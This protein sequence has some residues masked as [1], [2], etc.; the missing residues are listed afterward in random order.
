[1]PVLNNSLQPHAIAGSTYGFSGTRIDRLGAAEY[2]LVAIAADDSGSVIDFRQDME[3]CV[4]RVVCACLRSPRA[5]NL[6]LRVLRFDDNVAEIHGFKPVA[7]CPPDDYYGML[8]AGGWTALHDAAHNAVESVIR[9]GGDLRDHDFEVNGIVFVITDGLDNA[10]SVGPAAVKK[11]VTA[12]LKG[13]R[14][15]SLVTVLVGVDV[16]NPDVA[17][18]LAEFAKKAG[19]TGYV[20]LEKADERTLAGL[21]DFVSRSIALQSR[22]LGTGSAGLVF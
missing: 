13:E 20:E 14:L 10:S 12:G 3:K 6:M 17:Q 7:E 21:A 9:Y 11:A 8:H 16:A 15:D 18:G 4:E 5:D 19:F 22:A 1:M 2:T